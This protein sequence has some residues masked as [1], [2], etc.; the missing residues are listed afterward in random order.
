MQKREER[1]VPGGS[2]VIEAEDTL[3]LLTTDDLADTVRAR[4]FGE[5]ESGN[6]SV[7]EA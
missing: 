2:T 5:G 7:T 6:A 1:F 4:L 3:L